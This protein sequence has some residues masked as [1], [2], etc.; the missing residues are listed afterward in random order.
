MKTFLYGMV[1]AL[2]LGAGLCGV[3]AS[4]KPNII[5][6]LADDMGFSDLGCYG[7][8][9]PTPHLDTLAAQGLRFTQFYNGA[10]CCPSRASLLTGLYPHQTGVG[11]M[12]GRTDSPGYQGELNDRCVTIAEVL[13]TAGYFTAMTGKWHLGGLTQNPKNGPADRGFDRTL[14]SPSGGFY[15]AEGNKASL[16]LNGDKIELKDTRLPHNWY[17][18]DLW[19]TYGLKF[20]DEALDTKKPFYLHLCYNAPHYPLQ[21]SAEEI[22]AFRGKYK[23]GWEAIR[24]ARY[25]KQIRLG[26][27]DASGSKFPLP[28]ELK[29]WK[30]LSPE[31]RDRQDHMMATYAAVVAHLDKSIGDLVAGL[32]ER[33]VLDNTLILFMSDNGGNAETGIGKTSGDPSQGGSAW[34]CGMGWAYV[35]NTPL[36]MYKHFAHEGGISSPLIAHWPKGI[37]AKGELR[38]QPSHLIDIM[39]TC[40]DI[41]EATYPTDFNGKSIQSLE[42]NSLLSVFANQT[43]ER[44]KPLFWEHEG[45]A[46]I[47]EGNMKLVRIGRE[48]KWELYDVEKDRT[49]LHDLAATLPELVKQLAGQW[50]LWADR[51]QIKPYP[52][53]TKKAPSRL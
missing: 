53:E 46:A 7:S 44:K 27:V 45:N 20:I 38:S 6:I 8:E 26:V 19:T 30:E 10:R 43:T 48:G 21:A 13:K 39:A 17:S 41:G 36:R 51:T 5:V 50:N 42:G 49:E 11:Y 34:Y 23:G 29:P 18:T 32:K 9:I 24:A 14:I 12:M 40:V 33:K 2:V 37:R 3:S 22:A 52:P 47:R 4:E 1:G 15:Y 35:Q 25:E 31:E 16:E 28:K